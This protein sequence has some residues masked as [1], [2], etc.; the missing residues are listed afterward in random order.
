MVVMYMF[1]AGG[2]WL[3]LSCT[4]VII[5]I[6]Y[7]SINKDTKLRYHRRVSNKQCVSVSGLIKI[8]YLAVNRQNI[9]T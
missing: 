2:F 6:D 5:K 3:A 8:P 4:Q 9:L 1:S 7:Y